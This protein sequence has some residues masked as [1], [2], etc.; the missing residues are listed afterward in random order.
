MQVPVN[1]VDEATDPHPLVGRDQFSAM[2]FT[3][4]IYFLLE[5]TSLLLFHLN[6]TTF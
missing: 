2:F 6:L 4:F 5:I 1:I 3:L